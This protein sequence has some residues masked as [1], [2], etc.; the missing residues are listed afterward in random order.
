MGKNT[1]LMSSAI[2]HFLVDAVC[3]AALF[4]HKSDS[5]FYNGVLLYNTLAFTGQAVTGLFADR[6]RDPLWLAVSGMLLCSLCAV[7]PLGIYVCAA[8]LGIGNNLFHVGGGCHVLRSSRDKAAPLGIFV[9]PG[10]LGVA[11][12]T[13]IPSAAPWFAAASSVPAV[14]LLIAVKKE[15]QPLQ[16]PSQKA[17][18]PTVLPVAL[19]LASVAVRAIGGSAVSFSWKAGPQQ[20]LIL[21]FFVFAGKF[22]GG[23]LCDRL[24]PA[25]TAWLSILPAAFLTAFFQSRM[26][27]SLAGQWLLNLTMPVTLYLLARLLESRPAA[28]FGIAAAALWPGT[29][30]GQLIGSYENNAFLIM[31]AFLFGWLAILYT[32]CILR[33]EHEK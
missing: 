30:A 10:A 19:L 27:L 17:Q 21:A 14:L 6:S 4:C 2:S 12:G 16:K 23:F 33:K 32:T 31:A 15:T 24:G 3:V 9:A 20:A 18:A 7:L 28:A 8:G 22:L 13:W 25:K 5:A 11:L 1:I 29:L 26:V